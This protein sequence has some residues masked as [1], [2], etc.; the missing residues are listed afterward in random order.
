MH[1]VFLSGDVDEEILDTVRQME[2]SELRRRGG[3]QYSEY[4]GS[5]THP[6][7]YDKLRIKI[8]IATAIHRYR[9]SARSSCKDARS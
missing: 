1:S 6:C 8:R 3:E 2:I 5:G 4:F 9:A 7:K